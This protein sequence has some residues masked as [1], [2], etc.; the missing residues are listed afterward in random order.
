MKLLTK[1]H[2]KNTNF[3]FNTFLHE[4]KQQFINFLEQILPVEYETMS[5]D[6]NLYAAMRYATLN[7]GKC[8]RPALVYATGVALDM[9]NYSVLNA[10]A[11]GVELIHSYSLVHDDLPAMDNDDFRRGRPSCHKI[12][13][14]ATAILAGDALQALAF[15]VL[16]EQHFNPSSAE[17]RIKMVNILAT[18]AGMHGMVLGQGEDLAAE[19]KFISLA[20]LTKLHQ[21]KTGALI[22]AAIHLGIVAT[23]CTEPTKIK[24]LLQYGDC[25]G[26]AFQIHDDILDITADETILGKPI[27]S[28]QRNNKSTF[29]K[30]MGLDQAKNYALELQQKAI[31]SLEIFNINASYLRD[32]ACY[33]VQREY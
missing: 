33:F 32:L 6:S 20:K 17:T 18:A 19:N 31:A 1:V 27:N 21:H 28:D 10:A 14:E 26:L 25:I 29:P 30:L 22:K 24:A 15:S 12:F 2:S 23:N 9:D 8:L 3:D 4:A 5:A 11:A 16:S 7:V 13:G